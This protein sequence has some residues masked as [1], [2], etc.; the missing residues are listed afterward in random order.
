M[1]EKTYQLNQIVYARFGY[2]ID[3]FKVIA[4]DKSGVALMRMCGG[5]NIYIS[6]KDKREFYPT[7]II[8]RK[9]WYQFWK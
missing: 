6:S 9:K 3:K 4:V 2:G 1:K 8:D 5:L 7:D